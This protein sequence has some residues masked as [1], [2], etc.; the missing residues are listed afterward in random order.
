MQ[1]AVDDGQVDTSCALAQAD[2]VQ[3]ERIGLA[4]VTLVHGGIERP[5][6]VDVPGQPH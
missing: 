4:T 1:T 5:T 3:N 2:F 6:D